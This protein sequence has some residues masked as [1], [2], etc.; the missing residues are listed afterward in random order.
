MIWTLRARPDFSTL[1]GGGG[2]AQNKTWCQTT[3]TERTSQTEYNS[4]TVSFLYSQLILTEAFK[5]QPVY[6]NNRPAMTYAQ[7][8]GHPSRLSIGA[9]HKKTPWL[10]LCFEKGRDRTRSLLS[11]DGRADTGHLLKLPGRGRK[12]SAF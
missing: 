9:G 11:T 12:V 3:V 6:T 5:W 8:K 4:H 10:P 2:V 1:E 7:F